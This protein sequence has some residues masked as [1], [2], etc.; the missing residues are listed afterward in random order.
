M[1]V[2]NLIMAKLGARPSLG[3][4]QHTRNGTIV[5]IPTALWVNLSNMIVPIEEVNAQKG[6]NRGAFHGARH[7]DVRE[8]LANK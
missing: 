8:F 7:A 3:A 2:P 1:L 6:R 5:T 4:M